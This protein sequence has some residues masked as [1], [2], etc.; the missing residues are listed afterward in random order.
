M[1]KAV[2]STPD[3]GKQHREVYQQAGVSI[4]GLT[5]ISSFRRPEACDLT[6]EQMLGKIQLNIFYANH[7]SLELDL[8]ILKGTIGYVA[9]KAGGLISELTKEA[10]TPRLGLTD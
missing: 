9:E 1:E 8:L 2:A 10:L 6:E 3:L 5:Q 7:A 4:L